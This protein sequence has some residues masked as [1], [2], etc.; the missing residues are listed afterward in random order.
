MLKPD[1]PLAIFMEQTL[2]DSHGKMGYGILRFSP[3]PV[4]CVIDSMH[5]GKTVC[6]VVSSPRNCPVVATVQE[7]AALGAQVL[8]LGIAPSG[9]RLPE[10]WLQ[11]VDAA[12]EVGLSIV[13]GLYD[14][15]GQRYTDLHP[16]QWAWDIRREP[17]G[18]G[19]GKGRARELGNRRVL[20]VVTDMAT[21]KLSAGLALR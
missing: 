19:V 17:D 16:G 8:V 5:A 12:V 1:Q 20:F 6:D 2:G 15:L 11:Q 13:N 9:G 21:G 7:A 4:V 18:L 14:R 3:N 10:P